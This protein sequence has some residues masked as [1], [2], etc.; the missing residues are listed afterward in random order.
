MMSWQPAAIAG[1][2]DRHG[3][4]V[5]VGNAANLA[6][7]DPAH[8]WTVSGALLASK[9]NNTPFEGRELTGQVRHTIHNGEVVVEN[10][11]ATR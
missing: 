1:L 10:G 4:P 6:V 8:Q 7:I 3:L 9:A 5:V 2:A 11:E